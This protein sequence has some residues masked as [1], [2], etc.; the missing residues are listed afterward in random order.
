MPNTD[1][2]P[3]LK[4]SE[5]LI[6]TTL[7]AGDRHGYAIRQEILDFTDGSVDIEA[8]TLYRH[9]R[10][11]E[12]GGHIRFAPAPSDET[13]SRRI[14]YRLTPSGRRALAAEMA[15]LRALVHL[16]EERGILAAADA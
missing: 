13:D 1:L 15:R 9:L 16:A 7:S 4:H 3:N 14:Y 2:R 6:L 12:E 8:G 11:L 5:L 10:A